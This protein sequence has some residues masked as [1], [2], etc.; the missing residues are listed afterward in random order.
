[1]GAA[2]AVVDVWEL[3]EQGDTVQL[4]KLMGATGAFGD[5][6]SPWGAMGAAGDKQA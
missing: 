1:M 6:G 4:L 2:G 3:L 5:R